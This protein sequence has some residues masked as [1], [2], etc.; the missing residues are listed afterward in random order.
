ME[1][2]LFHRLTLANNHTYRQY[3]NSQVMVMS[4]NFNSN[5]NYPHSPACCKL[6]L[7]LI[8]VIMYPR[9]PGMHIKKFFSKNV[10]IEFW[11]V[12][13][14]WNHPSFVNIGRTVVMDTS[15]ERFSWVPTTAWQPKNLI[16]FSKKV[17]IEFWLVLKCWN[18]PRSSM[19]VL[20]YSVVIGTWLERF[21][22]VPTTTVLEPKKIVFLEKCLPYCFCCHVL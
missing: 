15:M 7:N 1:C 16:F 5:C 21:S 2:T 22:R 17:E 14:R 19:S 8:W 13:K 3:K 18:H 11:L 4:N 10:K 12:P 9:Y 20:Q 6:Y